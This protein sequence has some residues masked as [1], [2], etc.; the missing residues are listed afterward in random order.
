MGFLGKFNRALKAEK[1]RTRAYKLSRGLQEFYASH[2]F[3]TW[4]RKQVDIIHKDYEEKQKELDVARDHA[5]SR[6]SENFMQFE[7]D[8]LMA[9][10]EYKEQNPGMQ[11]HESGVKGLFSR[12]FWHNLGVR[13]KKL[14]HGKEK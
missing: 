1:A 4:Q 2:F 3:S 12:A 7:L 10:D 9:S 6:L 13:A 11:L 14:S 8:Y 5:S